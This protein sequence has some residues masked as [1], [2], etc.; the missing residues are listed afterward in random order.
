[1]CSCLC[2]KRKEEARKKNREAKKR[3][4]FYYYHE[5]CD[6]CPSLTNFGLLKKSETN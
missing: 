2:H 5:D 3:G 1:M 6:C 4:S